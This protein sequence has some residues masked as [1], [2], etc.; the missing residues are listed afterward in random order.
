MMKKI[1][2]LAVLLLFVIVAAI[3]PNYININKIPDKVQPVENVKQPVTVE[4]RGEEIL[5]ALKNND[6][7]ILSEYVHPEKGV[8][9][10]PYT[11]VKESDLVFSPEMVKM[12]PTFSRTFIWG[13]YDGSGEPIDLPFGQYFEKFVYDHDYLT[14]RQK[15]VNSPIGSGN[16]INNV[17]EFYPGATVLEYHFSG[18]DPKYE[19]MDWTSLKLVLEKYN[20]E[21]Y[22]VGIVHDGW[23]I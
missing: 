8:R 16:M 15:S 10:S 4:K 9:L 18:F 19:G 13:A 22:L 2:F 6:M 14:A 7:I 11:N 5:T 21:W 3:I 12:G 1:I 20:D 23:T 17:A